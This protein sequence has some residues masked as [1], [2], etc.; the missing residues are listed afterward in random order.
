MD[1]LRSVIIHPD[2]IP[3]AG[4]G[5]GLGA[6]VVHGRPRTFTHADVNNVAGLN[7]DALLAAIILRFRRGILLIEEYPHLIVLVCGG[8]HQGNRLAAKGQSILSHVAV[9]GRGQSPAGQLQ[10]LQAG[11]AVA[12]A[13]AQIRTQTGARVLNGNDIPIGDAVIGVAAADLE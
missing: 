5:D 2:G 1:A 4:I 12:P 6:L 7:R 9:K 10:T 3:G 11:I 8:G 13:A